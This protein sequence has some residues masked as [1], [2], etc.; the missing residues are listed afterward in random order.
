MSR[1]W[2]FEAIYKAMAHKYIRK[3]RDNSGRWRYV[4]A[5]GSRHGDHSIS[6]R[7]LSA[8]DHHI[9]EGASFSAGAGKGH[10][11]VSSVKD[12]QVTFHHEGK[13]G[14]RDE[15]Q[16][17]SLAEFKEHI[18]GSHKDAVKRHAQKGLAKRRSVLSYALKNGTEKQQ[19]RARKEIERWRGLHQDHLP[20]QQQEQ[21]QAA[22]ELLQTA[23]SKGVSKES[24][25]RMLKGKDAK[26]ASYE[27]LARLTKQLN[28]QRFGG[29]GQG[30]SQRRFNK[31]QL[32]A[33]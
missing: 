19:A 29:R 26:S 14:S 13:K 17:M 20:S 16:T 3:Y 12:G 9:H 2:L 33:A 6:S 25:R 11:V 18:H 8:K 32:R 30:G 10:L 1:A 5:D 4:Y 28:A 7:R 23:K 21:K 15:A 27:D 31:S 24:L 22:R